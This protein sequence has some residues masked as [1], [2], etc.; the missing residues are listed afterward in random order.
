MKEDFPDGN[1]D[2]V[3]NPRGGFMGFWFSWNQN[4]YLQ[5]EEEYLCFKIEIENPEVQVAERWRL[6]EA[7]MEAGTAVGL[8]LRKPG[9]F[10]K[11][12]YMTV[13]ILDEEYRKTRDGLIALAET[14]DFIRKISAFLAVVKLEATSSQLT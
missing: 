5:M 9:R 13:C 1:W 6:H 3:A 11:G 12:T 7:I 10:G 8:K 2:D 14:V 4:A